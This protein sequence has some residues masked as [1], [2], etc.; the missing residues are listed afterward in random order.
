MSKT[1]AKSVNTPLPADD[2]IDPARLDVAAKPAKRRRARNRPAPH[3]ELQALGEAA[4]KRAHSR[5]YPPGVMLEPAGR[6][7]EEMTPPHSDMDLWTLQ[8]ADAF[9]TRSGPV[10]TTFLRQLE[11]LCGKSHYDADARQWRLDEN[12]LCTALAMV[13]SIKPKNE[14]EAALAAQMVAVHLLQMKVAA[15]SIHNEYDTKTAAVAAK[16]ARTFTMQL[17]SLRASRSRKPI[18]R[19]S[20]KVKKE[21]HQHVHY[22]DARGAGENDGQ[23][24][25]RAR[26]TADEC[27]ALPSAKPGGQSVPLP[28]NEG[29][30][31]VQVSR[32]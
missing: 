16:L 11:A 6:D 3:P 26:A 30:G 13:N 20:I 10:M 7:Q 28:G 5:A 14:M 8:L 19:Q 31:A 9:G 23:P 15:W 32:R 27:S 18:A 12:E 21:L 24:H 1:K 2:R 22:H 25:G 4:R 17:D 29:Q